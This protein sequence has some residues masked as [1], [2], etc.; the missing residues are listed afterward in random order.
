MMTV[1]KKRDQKEVLAK[2]QPRKMVISN[3]LKPVKTIEIALHPREVKV[4]KKV[5]RRW[6][7]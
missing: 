1:K 5:H 2:S 6:I 3:Y 7:L 4:L